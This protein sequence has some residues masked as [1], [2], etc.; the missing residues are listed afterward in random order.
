[1]QI[2]PLRFEEEKIGLF[3]FLIAL[4]LHLYLDSFLT[5]NILP[6]KWYSF[7]L[8]WTRSFYLITHF[9]D[10]TIQ[11]WFAYIDLP[12]VWVLK[13]RRPV[14]KSALR[15]TH[16]YAFGFDFAISFELQ[17]KPKPKP[18]HSDNDVKVKNGFPVCG[19]RLNTIR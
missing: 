11:A 15:Q 5:M 13:T 16:S 2:I 9:G 8:N 10:K 17:T 3:V 18:K 14:N 7:I 6:V 19:Y 12:P 4:N 1:M